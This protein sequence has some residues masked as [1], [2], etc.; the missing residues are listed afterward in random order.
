MKK[1]LLGFFIIVLMMS[2]LDRP[3]L[4][5]DAGVRIVSPKQKQVFAPGDAIDLE[6]EFP[7]S[8]H[9]TDGFVSTKGM[10]S[11]QAR[12]FIGTHFKAALIIPDNYAGPLE[13]IPWVVVA[14]ESIAGAPL[15][16][17]VR[18]KTAPQELRFIN[19]NNFLSPDDKDVQVYVSGKY[20]DGIELDL[21]SSVTGTTFTSNNSAVITVDGN[22]LCTIAGKGQAVVT[23][24]NN[25]V[26][27]FIMFVVED[28]K[29][30]NPPVDITDKVSIVCANQR[31][32]EGG[33]R[34]IQE[35]TVTNKTDLPI[36]G[37][38]SLKAMDVPNG[39]RSYGDTFTVSPADGLN[40]FPGQSVTL[41][42]TFLLWQE[43][44][45]GCRFKLYDHDP[46]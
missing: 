21:S 10:G 3:A 18:P 9:A 43:A 16:V 14:G 5:D 13:L 34:V 23:V 1:I 2:V 24:E 32:E 41:E 39:A 36:I 29:D 17:H 37:P 11:L 31:E 44:N 42:A 45:I 19:R 26:R 46:V 8:L 4:A 15:T 25:G 30:P 33:H 35:V 38:F 28:P 20:S 27:G 7:S 22:G 40:L 12:E 6:V